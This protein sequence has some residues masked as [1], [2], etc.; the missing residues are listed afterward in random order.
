MNLE[1]HKVNIMQIF[2]VLGKMIIGDFT[3]VS[4]TS[5][6]LGNGWHSLSLNEQ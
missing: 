1:G 5:I 4:M 2:Q 6:D 3:I